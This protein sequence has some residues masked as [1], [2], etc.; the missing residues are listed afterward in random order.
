MGSTLDA[1][2]PDGLHFFHDINALIQLEPGGEHLDLPPRALSIAS[3]RSTALF[4]VLNVSTG[5]SGGTRRAGVR[6]GWTT[7]LQTIRSYEKLTAGGMTFPDTDVIN[8]PSA[9][10]AE[11]GRCRG[12]KISA[13]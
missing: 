13:R 6:L 1:E 9:R 8:P 4:T 12:A 5:D 2:A 3:V 11:N 7:H 10:R